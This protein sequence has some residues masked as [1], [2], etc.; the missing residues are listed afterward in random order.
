M[1]GIGGHFAPPGAPSA[2]QEHSTP[3]GRVYYYNPL[4]KVTQWTKPEEMMT[5]AERAL[6]NQPWKEY[7]AE[8]GRKYWYNTETKQSSW[9]MPDVYKRAL[10]AGDSTTPTGPSAS[11]GASG[12][13]GHHSGSFDH[14]HQQRDHRDRDYRDHREPL[15]ESRQLTY[16]INVQAQAF[17]SASNDPEYA[18]AEEAEA[19]FVKLLR[20]NKVQPDWTWEQAIRAIVKDPQ[21]RAI[22]DPRE[23]KAAFEKY[24]HDVVVQDKERAKE[25]L[26]KLRADFATM[27]R[28]HPEIKYYTR[29]K[30]ARSIIEGE[31]IFRSTNDEN[32]RRQLFEDYVSDLKRAHKEQQVTMRKSAMD[33]LIDLLPTLSLEPYTRWAEAQ[34]TIQNTPLF[35]SDEKY[36]TLSKFD[37]LTVFQNHVK[38]LE[39]NFNDSKQEEKNKKFRQERKARDNFKVLLAE[40]KKD[41]KITAGTT[42]TQIH[43]LIADDERYRAVAGNPGSSAMEL[44]WDVVEEEE[45]ALRGTRNDV[46][47]VID[48]KRFE[49]TP[50]TTFEEFEVVVKG[51]AR[52]ANIERKILELIFERIQQKRTK[53]TDEDK[54]QRRALDDLR[55]AMKRLEPPI[56]VNDTYEQVKARLAQSEA[57]RAV[58]SEEARRSAFDKYIRRLKDKDE[59][60]EKERQ[61]RRDRPDGH[62]DRGERSYRGG[63]SARSRSRSP[64]HNSYEA[65]RRHAMADRERNYSRKTSA[66]EVLLSDRRSTDGHHDSVRD[67]DRERDR[68]RDRVSDRDRERDRDRDRDRERDRD[69]A[70]DYRD[71]DRDRDRERE[72]DRDHGRDRDRDRDRDHRDHRDYD[73]RSR[74]A[75]DFNHYDRER[76]TREEDR[77]RIYRRRVLERDVD[78]LPYGDERPSSSSRRPRPEEDD[79]D[80]RSPRQ[81]KRV[82]VEDDRAASTATTTA[83]SKSAATTSPATVKE[84]KPP[85]SVR[86]GSE[87]GEIEED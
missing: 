30:T 35:Q 79:H 55:A 1:N 3:D 25:R 36:K 38:A 32:E 66:A 75:D 62:R 28:S 18:T 57:F 82:K 80:R 44:L 71:R 46:L 4:T 45:R 21:F 78:E 13:G 33:G 41:G 22:K 31:T 68:D 83:Q 64:E 81:A 76:R 29:W 5:P 84:E 16:G 85:N 8:G 20:T 43:P 24:C 56:T 59:E 69:R 37:V 48:D 6:A 19:A 34:G 58:N 67:R 52:T 23:R 77:E 72:R 15:G 39:R 42:W 63:R 53:R 87:E 50:K 60:A 9:E 49:V 86:A 73:R 40:L 14:H 17:V 7:T 2:W 61:R 65:E 54:V 26:T 70:R 27:L 12:G 11:F 51:D 74:P 47:D 10:G